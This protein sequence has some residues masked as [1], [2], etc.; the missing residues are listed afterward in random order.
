[1]ARLRLVL[2]VTGS[3]SLGGLLPGCAD[4][5]ATDSVL[6]QALTITAASIRE[7]IGVIAADSLL[8]RATP[9]PG[10]DRAAAYAVAAFQ[11]F[12]LAPG[13]SAGFLQTW[14]APGG[15]APNVI[16]VLAGSDPRLRDEYVLFVAHLDHIGVPGSGE[17]CVAIGADSICNGADDNGSGTAAVIELARA[18]AG[19]QRRPSRSMIFLLVWG[20]ELGMRGAGVPWP[21][22]ASDHIPFGASGVPSLWFFAGLHPD[23]HRPSDETALI[24]AEKTARIVRL[25]YYLGLAIADAPQRPTPTSGAPARRAIATAPPL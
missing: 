19:L 13:P 14:S 12:G 3:A 2:A 15:P 9:S 11:D 4:H 17:G 7:R 24:D 22:G 1:M 20:E 6:T 21:Y 10:L 25:V 16:G 23:R 18:F 8:G 5:Q